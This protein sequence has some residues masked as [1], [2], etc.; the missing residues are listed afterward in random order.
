MK[1]L[2]ENRNKYEWNVEHFI[3]DMGLRGTYS[4][5]TCPS[6]QVTWDQLK[7]GF[8]KLLS[9]SLILLL[10]SFRALLMSVNASPEILV[11]TH[12]AIDITL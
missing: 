11:K 1:I 6:P 8:T 5:L 4:D 7:H 12:Q 9:Q 2:T 10:G 3:V